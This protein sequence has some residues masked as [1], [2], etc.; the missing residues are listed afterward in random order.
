MKIL[1]VT[2]GS[3]EWLEVR[4]RHFCASDA[5]AMM[6]AST[7]MTRTELVRRKA[8]SDVPEVDASTQALFDRGHAAEDAA[9]QHLE[10]ELGEDLYPTTA[11]DDAG[12]LLASFDGITMDG[13]T[14]FEHKLHNQEL[15]AQVRAGELPPM[16]YW[17]LEQQCLIAGLKR[18]IFVVSDGTPERWEC[19]DYAPVPGRAEQLL[20]GWKQF[21]E[22]VKNYRHV[23]ADPVIVSA[24]I[25]DLPALTVELVGQ[26]KNSNLVSF[27]AAV[28]ARIQAIS[29]NLQTDDDFAK[30]DKM[31]KFLDDG[32]SRLDLVKSQALAQTSSIDELF[33]TI[34]SLKG[35][36]R[37]K[38]LTLTN[39]VKARK[40]SIREEIRREGVDA[41]TAHLASLNRVLG[42]PYMPIVLWAD[43][44]GVMKGKKTIT[45]LRDAVATELARAKIESNAIADRIA[46]NLATLR[47]FG[48]GSEF[49]F[50]DTAQIVLKANDDLTALVKMRLAEHKAKEEKRQE[51]ERERIRREELAKIEAERVAA[52]KKEADRIAA[53]A[54]A[55]APIVPALQY[56]APPGQMFEPSVAPKPAVTIVKGSIRPTDDAIIAAVAKAFQVDD[57]KALVWLSDMDLANARDRRVA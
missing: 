22:D 31:V 43:F 37:A 33:R 34:D 56:P 57:S 21:A 29:T 38:R 9:R 20:A 30:A 45:S 55:A 50:S 17:Q 26:V 3:P 28:L 35:E 1:N 39:L 4:S 54:K 32:E 2:Q 14:G 19:L 24:P 15:A 52:E 8:T 7:F 25:D 12:Y 51:E 41:I 48:T 40:E 16:Y 11:T 49:L 44:A 42:K 18:V 10:A 53:Q 36:M 23:E 27:K 5:P 13:E 6:G 47:E 46:I